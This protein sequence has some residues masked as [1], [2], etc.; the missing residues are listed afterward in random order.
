MDYG[1]IWLIG[2]ICF[3]AV[4]LRLRKQ[5]NLT[6]KEVWVSWAVALCLCAVSLFFPNSSYEPNGLQTMLFG[7]P[8]P[9]LILRFN[10]SQ[11]V[12][13]SIDLTGLL[14]AILYA[15]AIRTILLSAHWISAKL[16]RNK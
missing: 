6:P 7:W 3:V 4:H 11:I 10:H 13:F 14:P 16:C 12:G 2:I 15:F 8:I 5:I 1:I 9:L